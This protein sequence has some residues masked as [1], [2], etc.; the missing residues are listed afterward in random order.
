MSSAG[1]FAGSLCHGRS[2]TAFPPTSGNFAFAPPAPYP[3][4]NASKFAYA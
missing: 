1:T 2:V 4:N 3:A